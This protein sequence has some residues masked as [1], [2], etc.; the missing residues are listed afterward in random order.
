MRRTLRQSPGLRL[1][2]E[3]NPPALMSAGS[4]AASFL[5]DLVRSFDEVLVLDERKRD[6]APLESV[7]LSRL[8]NLYCCG[9]RQ[10]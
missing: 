5:D 4:D 7:E 6:L 3:F 9:P 2:I 10:A 8:A 1:F